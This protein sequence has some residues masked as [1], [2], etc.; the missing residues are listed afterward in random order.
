[1]CAV[2]KANAYGHGMAESA[3]AALRGGATTLAVATATEAAQLRPNVGDTPILVMGS[4]TGEEIGTLLAARAEITIWRDAS[5]ELLG[6][7][8]GELGQRA[9]VHVKHDSGMGRLGL[10]D[11][12]EA[13][14]L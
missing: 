13:A 11:P 4:V 6:A 9:R 14:A 7:I 5:R 2:V 12:D 3:R 1:M 10:R 8:A